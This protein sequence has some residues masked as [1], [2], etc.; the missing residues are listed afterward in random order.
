[1][2]I[3][4]PLL[5]N[6]PISVSTHFSLPIPFIFPTPTTHPLLRQGKAHSFKEGPRPSLLYP[7]DQGV[8]PKRIGCKRPIQAAGINSAATARGPV[9]CPSYTFAPHI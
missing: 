4:Y 7:A 2:K 3:N 6:I 5:F 8:H 1:M 9:L